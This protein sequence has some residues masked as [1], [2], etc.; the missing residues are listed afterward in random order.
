MAPLA[1]VRTARLNRMIHDFFANFH[2]AGQR[3]EHRRARTALEIV[4]IVALGGVC[5]HAVTRIPTLR[6]AIRS[7]RLHYG[8]APRLLGSPLRLSGAPNSYVLLYTSPS[9]RFSVASMPFHRKVVEEAQANGLPVYV[10]VPQSEDAAAYQ[11]TR[12]FPGAHLVLGRAL[13]LEPAA[14][15]TIL[16]IHNGLVQ[17]V[18]SGRQQSEEQRSELLSTIALANAR[19]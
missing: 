5:G 15:P 18:W 17:R 14:T 3:I 4:L 2:K 16:L 13:S 9:C 1:H 19:N 8:T 10:A 6:L 7:A 11:Q 12:E